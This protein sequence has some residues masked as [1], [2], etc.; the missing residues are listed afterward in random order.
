MGG[1]PELDA[2]WCAHLSSSTGAVVVSCSY[3]FA[4]RYTFPAAHDDIDDV[5]SWLADHAAEELGADPRVLTVG[6]ASAGGNLALSAARGLGREKVEQEGM[7]R[8]DVAHAALLF[9]PVLD[10]RLH[11]RDKPKPPNFPTSDPTSFLMPL[12]D[13]YAGPTRE[14]DWNDARL[15]SG[16]VARREELPRD[17]LIVA[18]GVDI[19]LAEQVRFVERV[20]KEDKEGEGSVELRVWEKGFH[21]WLECESL[22]FLSCIYCF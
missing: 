19:L 6:G 16:E 15:N 18:A 9:L 8:G 11:P 21:G 7:G 22:K 10:L 2:R 4:P 12:F 5:V 17:V 14:R 20:G 1:Y 3:R 13:A